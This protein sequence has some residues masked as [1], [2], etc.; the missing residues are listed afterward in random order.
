MV[1]LTLPL[2]D[3]LLSFQLQSI[4]PFVATHLACFIYTC[5]VLFVCPL[6]FFNSIAFAYSY[7]LDSTFDPALITAL[8]CMMAMLRSPKESITD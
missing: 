8:V 6:I 2:L 3:L 7:I 5:L 1:L 4:A